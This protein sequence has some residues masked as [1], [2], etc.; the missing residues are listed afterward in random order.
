[1]SDFV[2]NGFQIDFGDY[3]TLNMTVTK[4]QWRRMAQL[5]FLTIFLECKYLGIFTEAVCN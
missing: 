2:L 4:V 5:M 1:L 3:F